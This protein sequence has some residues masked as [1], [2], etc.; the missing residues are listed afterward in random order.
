[1]SSQVSQVK[2]KLLQESFRHF[3][4]AEA[5]LHPLKYLFWE[6]TLRCNLSCL[7]CGSDCQTD[8]QTF[9]MPIEDFLPVLDQIG[10]QYEPSEITVVLTGGEPLLRT[11]LAEC[12]RQIRARGFKWSMVSNGLGFSELR[13]NELLG[14]GIG[15]MTIS[16]DGLEANHNWLRN[17]EQS[18]GKAIQCLQWMIA[19]NR[20]SGDVVSCVNKKNL[21]ELPQLWNLL[22]SMGLN[23]WRLFTI[24]PIGRAS[25]YESLQLNASE[26]YTLMKFIEERRSSPSDLNTSFSC[27]S[28]TG[29]F[30][31]VVRDGF[32]FCRAGINIA[33][34]L[35][36]GGISACPN[37]DRS[38]VQGNIYQDDFM[39]VWSE[40]YV[41]FRQHDWTREYGCDQCKDY[42]FCE[43]NGMHWWNYK[44]KKL[45]SC[46]KKPYCD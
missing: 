5:K 37:I 32:F 38:M 7:H 12:G 11:D 27:E 44:D 29:D 25:N 26:F 9:D 46:I 13:F 4:Q 2:K 22:D 21:K 40:R 34:V 43:G 24:T 41:A 39:E 33:S 17:S 20:I 18:Y 36:D 31:G 15:A 35:A 42:R 16:L 3:R 23:E 6:C 1:M 19:N 28:Y 14:A 30:E 45:I 10:Q 8:A